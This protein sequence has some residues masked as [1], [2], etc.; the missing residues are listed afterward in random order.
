MLS[1]ARQGYAKR[2]L[3]TKD[4]RAAAVG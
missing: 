4:I 2:V 3:E 1:V